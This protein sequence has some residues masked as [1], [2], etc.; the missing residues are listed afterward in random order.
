VFVAVYV[1]T[2]PISAAGFEGELERGMRELSFSMLFSGFEGD[3]FSLQISGEHGFFLTSHHELGPV[4]SLNYADFDQWG[5][6]YAGSLGLFY[7]CNLPK[8]NRGLVHS[9][10]GVA[11]GSL[12]G[13][14]RTTSCGQS[15][16][17]G[18]F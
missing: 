6:E 9:S 11:N 15:W 10:V 7:R 13:F 5:S 18:L 14:C 12:G 3:G 8:I 2:T 4:L 1:V 16:V 17:F